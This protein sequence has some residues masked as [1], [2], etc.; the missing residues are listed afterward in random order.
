MSGRVTI[1]ANA[2]PRTMPSTAPISAVIADSSRTIERTWRRDVPI[3][4][5]IPSSRV[6]SWI[7]SASVFTMPNSDTMIDSVSSA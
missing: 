5:S 2:M 3:A 6:R 1:A 7:E 4:R